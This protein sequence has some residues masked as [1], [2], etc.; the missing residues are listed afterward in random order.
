[1]SRLS[2]QCGVLNISQSYRPPRSV[3]GIVL[4]SRQCGIL[5][6]SQP[7]RPPRPVTGIALLYVTIVLVLNVTAS[8]KRATFVFYEQSW[9]FLDRLCG[10]VARIPGY[11][12]RGPGSIPEATGFS[13]KQWLWN[14]VHSAVS[15]IEELLG[16]ESSGCGLGSREY[17]RRDPSRW[18][19]GT[20]YLQK[21]ALTSP[22]SGGRSVE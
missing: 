19:R 12:S 13:E 17:G 6:I 5:N 21:L 10:L 9:Q 1:V 14:G 15:T 8:F 11:R 18:P 20:F 16:R 3:T 22:T 4:L 7:Y 2:R